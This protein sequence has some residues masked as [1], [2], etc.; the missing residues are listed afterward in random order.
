MIEIK[1]EQVS[2]KTITKVNSKKT[3]RIKRVE[4]IERVIAALSVNDRPSFV[5][6][7][8]LTQVYALPFPRKKF[9]IQTATAQGM[10]W[11]G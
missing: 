1:G 9:I 4:K 11:S 5:V 8:T 3:E 6:M 7:T 2:S 10:T